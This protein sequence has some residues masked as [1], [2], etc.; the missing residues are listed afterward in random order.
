MSLAFARDGGTLITAGQDG[1]IRLWDTQ[2]WQLRLTTTTLYASLGDVGTTE[3]IAFTPEGYYE[4]SMGISR[5][6]RWREG[7]R[8]WPGE[9]YEHIFH[10]PDRVRKAIQDK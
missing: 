5:L 2:I 10:Q 1:T 9:R 3:W 8:L 4:G 7:V 6:I